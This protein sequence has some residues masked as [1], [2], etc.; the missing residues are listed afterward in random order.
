[1]TVVGA[2][3]VHAARVSARAAEG[4][5]AGLHVSLL[6][7]DGMV[8]QRQAR[9]PIWGSASPGST[10]TVA[11]DANN[12][13]TTANPSGDW[14]VSFPPMT[15]G[16]PHTI[17]IRA[18]TEHI[19]VNDV[20]V[21][22]VWVASGQ[23]NMEFEVASASDA[24]QAIASANDTRIRQFKVPQSYA[25]EP[26][27]ELA[28]GK[29]VPADREHVPNFSAVAY[30]FAQEIRRTADVPIGII[31]TTW[32][33]S[34]IEA[35]MS[36]PALR[37]SASQLQLALDRELARQRVA[38]DSLRTRLGELPTVDA[39]LVDGRA[40]WADPALDESHWSSIEV[41]KLWEEAG[42]A[43]MD[44]IG[45]YRTTFTL[46]AAEVSQR[47]RLGLGTIDDSDISWVNGV[48]IGGTEQAYNRPRVYDAPPS[49]LRAGR[50]VIAVRAEDTGGGGGIYGD[51]SLLYLE[52]GGV[53]RPLND[54]WKFRVG[55]VTVAPDGQRINK[56][57]TVL[58]NKMVQP[59]LPYPIKGVIW[60]QGESNADRLEDAAAYR[61]LFADM[62][63]S[64]R[65][66]W[67]LGDFPFIWVQLPNYMATV[68]N[69]STTSN[70]ATMRESQASA[71][72]LPNT[73]QAVVID[74]GEAGDIHPK[75]KHD[76]GVR[77]ADV[78]RTVAYGQRAER[79]A[80]AF[81]RYTVRGNR[82]TIEFRH[83]A[84]L[85]TRTP[86]AALG[87]F[88]IAGS[89]RHFVWAKAEVVGGKVVAWSDDVPRPV[90]IRYAWENNPEQANLVNAAGLPAAPFRT[91]PW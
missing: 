60:Y 81:R 45:W 21:G 51:P 65:G 38:L 46:T 39:G 85:K 36:R 12:R 6:F 63:T 75:N 88:A 30:F 8:I 37:L 64:W 13:S 14:R 53:K 3:L 26:S 28:G 31:N 50:N 72:R 58:Y 61:A 9:V 33:G 41:P 15:A 7:S 11:L 20:L 24:A 2:A 17:S 56:V 55:V 80:P 19:D 34:R 71:M 89:D 48:R 91:D 25:N 47:V 23:S 79:S 82:I 35:W 59:L 90:A 67:K 54:P 49:A 10:V 43:D 76:V 84:G 78:A 42:Y 69:P 77:L 70:W 18:G 57:P 29:W 1:M 68:A 62:I 4:P 83:A 74:I 86:G 22:D 52:V 73:G 16:G 27:A 66:A 5:P 32:G 87:G 44:G 40:V